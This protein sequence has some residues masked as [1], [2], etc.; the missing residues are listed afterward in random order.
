MIEFAQDIEHGVHFEVPE[1]VVKS[2]YTT[3]LK[4]LKA[5]R[6]IFSDVQRA[7]QYIGD[8]D[9]SERFKEIIEFIKIRTA[10]AVQ[11]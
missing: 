10:K 9:H 4:V 1:E 6:V 8:T 11:K 2:V 7:L 5:Q 3:G